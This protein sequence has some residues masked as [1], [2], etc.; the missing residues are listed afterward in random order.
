MAMVLM[1]CL[2]VMLIPVFDSQWMILRAGEE[3]KEEEEEEEEEQPSPMQPVTTA[4]PSQPAARE[5]DDLYTDNWWVG[6]L[7]AVPSSLLM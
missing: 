2:E 7:I 4:A 1:Q 6:I 3:L 5:R